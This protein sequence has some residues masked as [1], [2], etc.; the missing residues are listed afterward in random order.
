[1]NLR[2]L[3]GRRIRAAAES[4]AHEQDVHAAVATNVGRR[5]GKTSVSSR[6]TV[7]QRNGHTEV[8]ETR[9][10]ERSEGGHT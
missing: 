2:D 10:E 3:I 9:T 4:V 1:M 8:T 6:R 7:V 5:G